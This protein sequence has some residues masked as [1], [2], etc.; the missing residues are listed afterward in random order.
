MGKYGIIWDYMGLYGIIMFP[1]GNPLLDVFFNMFFCVSEVFLKFLKQL[2]VMGC[3]WQPSPSQFSLLDPPLENR[4]RL[5]RVNHQ[6]MA[7]G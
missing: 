2:Q 1:M 6:Q 5:G 7:I 3:G 4:Y